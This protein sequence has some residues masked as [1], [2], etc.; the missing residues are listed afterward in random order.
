MTEYMGQVQ[1]E[2]TVNYLKTRKQINQVKTLCNIKW[3]ML[4]N[5][6]FFI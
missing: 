6:K 1:T 4:E 5:T 3:P 2:P